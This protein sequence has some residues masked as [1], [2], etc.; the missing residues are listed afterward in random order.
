MYLDPYEIY[1]PQA[2]VVI[3]LSLWLF[4]F[5]NVHCEKRSFFEIF[6]TQA[7]IGKSFHN[8]MVE[9]CHLVKIS[10]IRNEA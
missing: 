6:C 7:S 2:F 3:L 5:L 8:A 9:S 10:N 1:G 4:F